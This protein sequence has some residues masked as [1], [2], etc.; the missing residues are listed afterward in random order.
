VGQEVTGLLLIL[1][2]LLLS[3]C[4]KRTIVIESDPPG[5]KV[6][7]NEHPVDAPTP[8]E[9]E[10]ITHGRYKFRLEKSGFREMTAREMVRAPIY[11]WIPLD[12]VAEYLLPIHFEDRHLFRYRLT[13]QPPEERLQVE[14]PEGFGV[15]LQQLKDPDPRIRRSACIALALHRDRSTASAVLEATRDPIPTV[16]MAALEAF[17]AIEGEKSIQRLL[18]ALRSDPDREV[19]WQAAAGLEALHS[20]EAVP[21]L[22][23]ALKD[24][25]SLVRAGAAEAL[26]GIPDPRAV[27]PLIQALRDRDTTVRRAATEGLGKIGD[28]A[29]VPALSRVLFYHDFQT[30]RRAAEALAR[31]KDPAS[32]PA[33]V[34]TFTDWD[35]KVRQTATRALIE[36]GDER[37]VSTLIRRLRGLKTWT[38]GHAAEVLA[39]LKDRRAVEPLKRAMVREPNPDT[40]AAMQQ[41][42]VA[43]GESP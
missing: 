32:G 7:I 37:I 5:A 17:R 9:Y 31:I 13:P 35:P 41:A 14:K 2:P 12:F 29:A 8:V 20:S 43:L 23:A 6:W 21:H 24:R 33:L 28:K 19:R 10:F 34:R 1:V 40:R 25:D 30:R 15:A 39:A 26:K 36:F 42:L 27:H 38:R 18:E 22:I 4:V 16:R 3:G 11:Q